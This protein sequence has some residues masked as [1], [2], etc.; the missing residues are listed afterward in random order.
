MDE[1]NHFVILRVLDSSGSW[2]GSKEVWLM[3]R[4]IKKTISYEVVKKHLRQQSKHKEIERKEEAGKG[5][6]GSY[7]LYRAKK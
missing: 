6:G 7:Y 5:P 2:L 4:K 3:A 1:L